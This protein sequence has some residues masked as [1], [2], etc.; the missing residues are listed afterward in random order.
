VFCWVGWL[1]NNGEL[2]GIHRPRKWGRGQGRPGG[3]QWPIVYRVNQKSRPHT[4]FIDIFAWA[5][6]FCIKFCTFIGNI[7]PRMC[8]D[9]RSFILTFSEMALIL[10]RAPIIFTGSSF[11]CSAISLLCK[12][13]EYSLWE[14]MLL[15]SSSNV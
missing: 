11:D 7:Y 12:N 2:A 5:Q 1:Q 9:F 4:S 6:S 14:M 10:L 13:A 8:T 3:H 15:F